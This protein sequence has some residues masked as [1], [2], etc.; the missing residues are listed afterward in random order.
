MD[1]YDLAFK[2]LVIVHTL[3]GYFFLAFAGNEDFQ[4][5]FF[6]KDFNPLVGDLFKYLVLISCWCLIFATFFLMYSNKISLLFCWSSVVFFTLT[7]VLVPLANG[8]WPHMHR[9]GLAN[10]AIRL[11]G[12]LTLTYLYLL[13]ARS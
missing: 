6:Y 7:G 9:Y 1:A 4:K 13:T 8:H 10:L 2:F 3:F 5:E 12:A 11:T